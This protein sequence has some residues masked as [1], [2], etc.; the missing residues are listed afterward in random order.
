MSRRWIR[1]GVVLGAASVV[2]AGLCV[3]A[4]AP[5]ERVQH[6][7]GAYARAHVAKKEAG[8]ERFRRLRQ[9]AAAR[10]AAIGASPTGEV[11]VLRIEQVRKTNLA[12]RLVD[13]LVPTV[14]ADEVWRSTGMEVIWESYNSG[15]NTQWLGWTYN[16]K[17]SNHWWVSA[18]ARVDFAPCLSSPTANPYIVWVAGVETERDFPPRK[19]RREGYVGRLAGRLFPTLFA[20]DLPCDASGRRIVRSFMQAGFSRMKLD[21]TY[22]WMASIFAGAAGG[23]LGFTI[24]ALGLMGASY[25]TGYLDAMW[26]YTRRCPDW[27]WNPY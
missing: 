19:A 17:L 9:E 25:A 16:E 22:N 18:D 24:S 7:T 10:F 5:D 26:N 3:S 20:D 21:N 12:A 6:L 13:R 4:A 15:R 2:A 23:P 27:Y 11:L 1:Y 14:L 8:D